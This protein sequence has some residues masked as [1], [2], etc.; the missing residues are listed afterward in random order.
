[1]GKIHDLRSFLAALEENG[2]LLT[3]DKEV[4]L[5]H[6]IGSVMA[7]AEAESGKACLF[8]KVAGSPYQV[9]GGMLA[10]MDN[11]S[12][13]LGVEK[14][15]ITDY[16]GKVLD[17]PIAPVVVEDAP[18]HEHVLVG[19]QVDMSKVPVPTHAPLDGGPIITGGIIHSKSI[20]GGRQNLSFQR[21][22]VKGKDKC[23][24]MINEWRHLK[25]FLDEA[26]QE[27][28]P[29]PISVAIG[30][31]PALYIA[32]GIRTDLD[33]TSL[34]GGMRGEPVKIVKSITNDIYVPAE[35][36]FVIEGEIQPGLREEEGPLGEFTGHYSAPWKSPVVKVTAICHRNSPIYQTI[37][38]ASFE[39][40]NLGN[41]LPRQPLLK[42]FAKYVSDGVID[43]HI[44]PYGDGF[45]ALIQLHK[46]NPGEPKN[47]ALAAMMTYVNIKNVIVV[48]EDVDIYNPADV[49]WAVSTRVK[50]DDDIFYIKNAQG[51]ELDPCSDTRGVQ[52]K[53]GIDATRSEHART[54]QR[55]VYPKVDLTKY[56]GTE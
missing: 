16:L 34:A 17:H 1:M 50:P 42:K 24:I 39:H 15:E 5:V 49:M 45:L 2:R 11:V 28:K 27:G 23:G 12:L 53:M 46:K 44:P 41:V 29:L 43:V 55:V 8:R 21:M 56:Q 31:D 13:A 35:A 7:T 26:E 37:N 32:A 36:E 4:N 30:C 6:E 48:D 40:I 20:H 38:G 52:T 9:A 51:H 19:D 18:C 14:K 10:S 22:H 3:I 47:V 25:E 54:I 33:E